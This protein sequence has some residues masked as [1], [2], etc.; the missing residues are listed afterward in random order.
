MVRFKVGD[1]AIIKAPHRFAGQACEVVEFYMWNRV[2][3]KFGIIKFPSTEVEV[4]EFIL[5]T[6]E[7]EYDKQATEKIQGGGSTIFR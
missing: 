3:V 5:H 6:S 1:V 2:R 7:L 4:H